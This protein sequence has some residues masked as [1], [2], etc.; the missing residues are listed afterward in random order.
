MGSRAKRTR[1]GR[2]SSQ[3]HGAPVFCRASHQQRMTTKAKPIRARIPIMI[4]CFGA[5]C[6]TRRR[7]AWVEW[8]GMPVCSRRR[9]MSASM[10]RPCLIGLRTARAS[11]R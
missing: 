3:A 4:T 11:F 6:M 1:A 2:V 5:R 10:R 9:T 8:P 7:A